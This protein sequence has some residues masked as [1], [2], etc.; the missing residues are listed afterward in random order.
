MQAA[1]GV[2]MPTTP[3]IKMAVTYTSSAIKF[4]VNGSLIGTD[5]SFTLP[6][7]MS[8][9]DV[10]HMGGQPDSQRMRGG[11]NQFVLFPTALTDAEAISLTTL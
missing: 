8:R 10:G 11:V 5:T 9:V 2:N 3:K 1:I 4:F 7:S 6:S